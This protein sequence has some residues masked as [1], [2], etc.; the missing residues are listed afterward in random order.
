MSFDNL[1]D[2]R[3]GIA[4]IRSNTIEY[5]AKRKTTAQSHESLTEE[6]LERKKQDCESRL[7]ELEA[8]VNAERANGSFLLGATLDTFIGRFRDTSLRLTHAFVDEAGYLPLIKAASL[9]SLGANITFLGDHKQLPP[10]CEIKENDFNI[11]QNESMRLWAFSSLYCG[12]LFYL[13]SENILESFRSQDPQ[14]HLV[15]KSVLKITHRFG[16]NLSKILVHLI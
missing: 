8:N 4:E 3:N 14:M 6:E 11:P 5:L 1:T 13:Q 9:F 2:I 7:A 12:S 10:I 16:D 15:S